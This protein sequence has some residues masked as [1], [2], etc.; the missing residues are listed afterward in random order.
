VRDIFASPVIPM[1][2]R[3]DQ[4]MPGHFPVSWV[5]SEGKGR[6]FYTSLGHREDLWDDDANVRDRV[7]SPEVAQRFQKHILGGIRWALG[8]AP[9][10]SEPQH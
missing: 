2:G 3:P 7:N 4:G 8:L 10:S 9:G 5:R 1:D 6:V